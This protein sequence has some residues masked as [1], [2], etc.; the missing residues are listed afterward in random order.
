MG[1]ETRLTPVQEVLLSLAQAPFSTPTELTGLNDLGQY[2]KNQAMSEALAEKLVDRIKHGG[3]YGYPFRNSY[4]WF[5]T[6]DGVDELAGALGG[7]RDTLLRELP[8]SAAWQSSILRRV[9]TA[10]V[11]YKLRELSVQAGGQDCLWHWHRED[12]RDGTLEIGEHRYL[13]VRRFGDVITRRAV[14]SRLGEMM[15]DWKLGRVGAALF[16]V[17][18]YTMMRFIERWLRDNGGGVYAWTVRESELFSDGALGDIWHVPTSTGVWK[19]SLNRM[20]DPI[21]ERADE[22]TLAFVK[23]ASFVR[24]SRPPT[25]GRLARRQRLSADFAALVS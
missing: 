7:D 8:V 2:R 6:G 11:A 17:T 21:S 5:L 16:I 22:R 15:E 19:H 13:H 24:T 1:I 25:R 23:L 14:A 10:Q 3:L 4:R 20:L 18:S 9:D 12:W